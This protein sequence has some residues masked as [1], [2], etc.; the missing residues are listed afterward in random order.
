MLR[1]LLGG[2]LM[3][4]VT[5]PLLAGDDKKPAP[6]DEK[7]QMEA[8]MKHATPG[9]AHKRLDVF[10]GKWA[11]TGQMVMGPSQP[12]TEM[13]G[14]VETKWILGGRFQE[15]H[16]RGEYFGQPFHGVAT[17]GYDNT[18]RHYVQSWIDTM[19]TSISTATGQADAAGTTITM[20]GEEIDPVTK[21]KSR[22][23]QVTRV[24]GPDSYEEVFSKVL[25][26]GKEVPV[27]TLKMTRTKSEK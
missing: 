27:M 18:Q 25:P 3:A 11:Y 7:A 26:D 16:V 15:S 23:K 19:T 4:L 20:I 24:T 5:A 12:P 22:G 13:K 8:W 2:L 6:A 14:T 9:A 21:T 1:A 17:L 10:V